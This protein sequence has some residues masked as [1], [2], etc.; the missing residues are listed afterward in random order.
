MASE[1]RTPSDKEMNTYGSMF[2]AST[3]GRGVLSTA[4]LVVQIVLVLYGVSCFLNTPKDRRK[5]RLRFV[6]ISSLIMVMW[7]I[8]ISFDLWEDFLI[9]YTG[10]P[11]GLSYLQALRTLAANENLRWEPIGDA[12]FCAAIAL[13][14][15][16]MASPLWRCL[17]LWTDRKW[18]VLFPSLACLGSIGEFMLLFVCRALQ[19][20]G[21]ILHVAMN[22]MITFL[23]VLRV[24]R[25]RYCFAKAFPDQ[26]PP[27]WYSE[28]MALIIESAAPLAIFG[29]C[30]IALR[31]SVLTQSA[32]QLQ[33]GQVI[34]RARRN[35]I[36]DIVHSFYDAFCTLSPQMIIVRVTMGKAW[37]SSVL[38]T[39]S[40]GANISQPVQFVHSEK[41][42][43]ASNISDSV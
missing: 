19:L 9:L 39:T 24:M 34:Q 15:I 30:A 22:I 2:A 23:I 28:V 38:E 32:R 10:G 8:N 13:G 41:E 11:D 33:S 27:R 21:A 25:V 40:E 5:G 4:L 26:K 20:A 3:F 16:L 18:V 14:D 43:T 36:M 31:G 37:N 35:I 7:T 1:S 6:I 12:F 42:T 17:I 29:I